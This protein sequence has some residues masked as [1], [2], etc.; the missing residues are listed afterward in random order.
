LK[1][2]HSD[3]SSDNLSDKA[4]HFTRCEG[5]TRFSTFTNAMTAVNSDVSDSRCCEC[6]AHSVKSLMVMGVHDAGLF[7]VL[8]LLDEPV[9]FV[10]RRGPAERV[11]DFLRVREFAG[12][13]LDL[14]GEVRGFFM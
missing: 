13:G 4:S 11:G 3:S 1:A 5:I 6:F 7:V 8:E 9:G 10:L 2:I 14:E 12:F